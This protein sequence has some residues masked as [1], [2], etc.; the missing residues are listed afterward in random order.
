MAKQMSYPAHVKAILWLGLPLVGGHLAQFAIGLTDTIMLGWYGVDALAAVTLAQSYF[1]V[2]FML[3]SGFALAV[4]PMV[5]A[6]VA[7]DDITSA[8]RATRMGLWLS[9]AFAVLGQGPDPQLEL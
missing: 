5:A 2:L 9:V 1:F 6:S 3:G 4:M 7:S 8:R